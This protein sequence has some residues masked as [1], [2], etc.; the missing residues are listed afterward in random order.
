MR[1]RKILTWTAFWAVM[2]GCLVILGLAGATLVGCATATIDEPAACDTV[3]LGTVPAS[4]VAGV[5]LPPQTFTS[6]FDFSDTVKKV[7]DIA[8]SLTTNVSQLTMNNNGD[9]QWVSRVDVSIAADGMTPQPFA[10]YVSNGDPGQVVSLNILM[11][12]GTILNYLEKPITLTF[13]VNGTAPTQ[14]VNFMN[15]MCVDV[16]GHVSKSL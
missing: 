16:S 5:T 1:T 10:S 6:N 11:D 15:T 2:A 9:L 4:P 7:S 3:T 12:S 14:T 13:T 8:D